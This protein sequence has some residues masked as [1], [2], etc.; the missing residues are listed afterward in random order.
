MKKT[1]IIFLSI[2]LVAIIIY[3]IVTSFHLQ[4]FSS[5]QNDTLLVKKYSDSAK[6]LLQNKP[7]SAILLYNKAVKR[8]ENLPPNH[9]INHLLAS[10]YVDCSNVYLPQVKYDK[11]TMYSF[12]FI[13]KNKQLCWIL[14]LRNNNAFYSNPIALNAASIGSE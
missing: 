9:R 2:L 14:Y 3:C 13:T 8:L 5:L 4:A 12:I 11:I 1:I 10:A 6:G 7:D